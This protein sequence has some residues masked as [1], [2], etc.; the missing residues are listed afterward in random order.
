MDR[1][2]IAAFLG[3]F[4]LASATAQSQGPSRVRGTITAIDGNT[5]SVKSREGQDVRIELAPNATFAYMKKVSF[6][7]IK[8]GTPLG[9][10]AVK[11]ADNKLVA[12]EVHVFNPDRP[13]P[14][15]GHRPWDLEAD[16]TMTNGRVTAVA[17]ASRGSELTLSYPGGQQQVLVSPDIPIVMAVESDR[18]V[19]V[20]GEYAY[21]AVT[22]GADGKLTATRLQV[23]RDGVRPPQ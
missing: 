4:L 23:S 9:T 22:A 11:G 15:E 7:D 5:L 3:A 10:S 1:F 16:S 14:G 6:G 21:I 12:R 2:R 8:P 13:I 20:P 17:P 19:I 18:S